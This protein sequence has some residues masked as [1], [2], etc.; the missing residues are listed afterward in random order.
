MLSLWWV[1]CDLVN[2]CERDVNC[3]GTGSPPGKRLGKLFDVARLAVTSLITVSVFLF[4]SLS[5]MTW[6]SL[7]YV[8]TLNHPELNSWDQ[9]DP[10]S[11][12]WLNSYPNTH[13]QQ[14]L[15]SAHTLLFEKSA[16]DLRA[17]TSN[18]Y[19]CRQKHCWGK[20]HSHNA[21]IS[22][23]DILINIYTECLWVVYKHW[24]CQHFQFL[25]FQIQTNHYRKDLNVE[26]KGL[27][28]KLFVNW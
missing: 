21:G 10:V 22:N 8:P 17:P 18:V 15:T 5:R 19:T 2:C 14:P 27:C 13:E 9:Y 4:C 7:A 1:H 24:Y 25:F 6:I 12:Y 16:A 28:L 26:N 23:F 20:T 11:C 3:W